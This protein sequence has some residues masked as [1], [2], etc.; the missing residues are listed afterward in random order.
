MLGCETR[1]TV[2]T[3]SLQVLACVTLACSLAAAETTDHW[4]SLF[5]GHDLAGWTPVN[6][7]LYTATNGVLHVEQGKGWLRTDREYTNFVFEA[8]WRALD[9]NYNSGFLI[10]AGLPGTPYPTNSW[11]VNLKQNAVG[12]LLRGPGKVLPAETP[13]QPVGEWLKFR[14]RV[15][16]K[17]LALFVHE[18]Q[19][20]KLDGVDVDHGYLGVQAEG[21]TFEFRNLRIRELP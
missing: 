16:G 18:R 20:W 5:T 21:K 9:T 17:S 14:L 10:R 12:E 3:F 11:Q 19:A 6:G 2:K 13:N 1:Q 15:E 4:T 8:E 7:G